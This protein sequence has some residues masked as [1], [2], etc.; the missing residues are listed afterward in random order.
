[1]G[2]CL[3]RCLASAADVLLAGTRTPRPSSLAAACLTE[4]QGTDMTKLSAL[5][6]LI[7]VPVVPSKMAPVRGSRKRTLST[8]IRCA[9]CQIVTVRGRDLGHVVLTAALSPAERKRT[10]LES[11]KV[12]ILSTAC[13]GV[14]CNGCFSPHRWPWAGCWLMSIP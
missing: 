12:G 9:C 1:M 11:T 10:E 6:A 2:Q 3:G 14:N 13:I 4:A 5:D 7:I 8:S